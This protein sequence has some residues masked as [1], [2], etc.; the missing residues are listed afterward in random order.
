VGLSEIDESVSAVQFMPMMFRSLEEVDHVNGLMRP[1]IEKRILEKGFVVLFWGDA[2]WI[3]FFSKELALRPSDVKPMKLFSWAGDNRSSDILKASGYKPVS[4]ETGDILPGFQTGLINAIFMIPYYALTTQVYA[5]APHMLELNWAPLLG[6]TVVTRKVWDALPPETQASLRAS[7][8][9]AGVAIQSDSRKES[10]EA[11]EAMKKRGL[12]VHPLTPEL[13]AEW[14]GAA[15][16]VYPQ[17]RGKIVPADLFD[18]VQRL[19]REYRSASDNPK[20]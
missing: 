13:E 10:R 2:G 14:R 5:N 7:A 9:E 17:I 8:K 6:G 15:E 18:E 4:L 16:A 1:V 19:L 12:M 20:G 3:R 11:V